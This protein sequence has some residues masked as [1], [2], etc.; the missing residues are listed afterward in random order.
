MKRLFLFIFLVILWNTAATQIKDTVTVVYLSEDSS[1]LVQ[2]SPIQKKDTVFLYKRYR[3]GKLFISGEARKIGYPPWYGSYEEF[4]ENG[5]TRRLGQ[6]NEHGEKEGVWSLYHENGMLDIV[7]QFSKD[8]RN[9]F[10]MAFYDTGELQVVGLY[11]I[12][13]TEQLNF[14]VDTRVGRWNY[15]HRNGQIEKSESYWESAISPLEKDIKHGEWKYYGENGNLK[16]TELY[17]K[18]VLIEN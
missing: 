8:L 15:Y 1:D 18:G 5:T 2:Y 6:Y 16:K 3:N 7:A 17:E 12:V 4:H 13:A 10:F 14:I 9:G 11:K